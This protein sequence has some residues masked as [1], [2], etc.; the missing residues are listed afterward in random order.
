MNN[1][2]KVTACI[3]SRLLPDGR[4]GVFI[5]GELIKICET[6]AE[7]DSVAILAARLMVVAGI[8]EPDGQAF[9]DEKPIEL[10]DMRIK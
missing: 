2:A 8:G 7:S 4:G 10:F 9:K 6:E 5:D 1:E 3:E